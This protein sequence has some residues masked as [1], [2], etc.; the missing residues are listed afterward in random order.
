L[1]QKK[2]R[3][4]DRERDCCFK[5]IRDRDWELFFVRDRDR[6]RDQKCQSRSTLSGTVHG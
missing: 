5:K 2:F 1:I 6:D 3:D 4:R